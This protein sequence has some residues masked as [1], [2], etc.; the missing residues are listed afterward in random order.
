MNYK[1]VLFGMKNAIEM[2]EKIAE[3][4]QLPLLKVNR[5][6]FADGEVVLW[7]EET[8]RN[9]NAFIIASTHMPANE[10]IME[11]LI[12]IDSLKRANV[13][14]ITVVLLYYGY[15][16][17]D[18]KDHGRKPITAKLIADLLERA[19]ATRIIAV[20]LHNPSIQ[21]FFNIPVDDLKGQYVLAKK[22]K[23][24]SE[25]FTVVSP[26]HGGA[27]RARILSE[28][29]ADT[30]K[31]AII[32][33]RRIGTNKTE[34]LGIIGD[35]KGKNVVIID[36]IIDTGGTII[37]AAKAVKEHGAKKVIIAATH[38]VFSRGFEMFQEAKEVDKVIITDSIKHQNLDIK[39]FS[40]LEIVSLSSF[41]SQTINAIIRNTSITSL[42]KI[43]KNEII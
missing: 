20:D 2:A 34:I 9:S 40:K 14:S 24:E 32:D 29:I 35:V 17:Q 42:Y 33:K 1:N 38:G 3:E 10:N 23:Q 7:S 19:G 36:D 37:K 22:I 41:V 30:V 4:T 27:V 6:V 13:K 25:R 11:L 39:K 21:G 18:R 8:V 16:R 5:E 15:A 12:F 31:I 43:I 28:L 26:D